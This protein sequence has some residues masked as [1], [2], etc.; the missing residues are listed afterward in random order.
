[1]PI[2]SRTSTAVVVA[3]LWIILVV[4]RRLLSQA[5]VVRKIHY[6]TA[7]T[8]PPGP[9]ASR[10]WS[11]VLGGGALNWSHLYLPVTS[12]IAYNYLLIVHHSPHH[13]STK[14]CHIF[15]MPSFIA[16]SCAS[17]PYTHKFTPALKANN[18]VTVKSDLR[19]STLFHA[20]PIHSFVDES[21]RAV[22]W[23]VARYGRKHF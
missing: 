19:T 13:V 4:L 16:L 6:A 22:R 8:L 14:K 9:L 23:R 3:C 21:R 11:P 12:C 7:N 5:C 20:S 10:G 1:M 2:S 18:L 17:Y 15:T